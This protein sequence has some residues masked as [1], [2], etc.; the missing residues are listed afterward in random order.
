[1]MM[2]SLAIC[3]TNRTKIEFYPTFFGALVC[4]LELMTRYECLIAC[5]G[6]TFLGEES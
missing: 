2:H 1:M 3:K 6:V 4:A 5:T